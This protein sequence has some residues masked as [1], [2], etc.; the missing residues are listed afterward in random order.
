VTGLHIRQFETKDT[1]VAIQLANDYALFDGP[2]SESDLTITHGFPEGI[3]VAEEDNKIVGL[4][5]GYFK[6][7]PSSVLETWG[8]SKVATIELLVVHSEYAGKGIGEALLERLIDIFRE[9]GTDMIG[10]T[11][12]AKASAAKHLYE[13]V[14]F[15]ISAFHMRK[16]LD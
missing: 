2:I 8:V 3:L 11:C 10:L 9:A 1:E 6:E 14:G 13:K 4:I 7:V 15:E 12:P 5:Y 16:R